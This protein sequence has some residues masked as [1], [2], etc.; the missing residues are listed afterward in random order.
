MK[1]FG[2]RPFLLAAVLLAGCAPLSDDAIRQLA[3]ESSSI[4]TLAESLAQ[5][6]GGR[7]NSLD[8]DRF[9]AEVST[10]TLSREQFVSTLAP[11]TS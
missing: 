8:N 11:T 2:F 6:D 3:R 1:T 5:A 10:D 9:L 4:R 7:V